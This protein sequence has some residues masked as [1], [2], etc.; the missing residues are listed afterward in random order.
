[1][2]W[3]V[4]A[5]SSGFHIESLLVEPEEGGQGGHSSIQICQRLCAWC[6]RG[7]HPALGS[8]SS[9]WRQK[10]WPCC[11]IPCSLLRDPG[12][13]PMGPRVVGSDPAEG[14]E[15]RWAAGVNL[16]SEGKREIGVTPRLLAQ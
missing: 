16:C 9:R 15:D 4:Y 5:E 3:S 12:G 8:H 6:W 13:S 1:V 2:A 7:S 14:W 11:P 10:L